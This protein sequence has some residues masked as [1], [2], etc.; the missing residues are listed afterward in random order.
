MADEHTRLRQQLIGES[1]I[2]NKEGQFDQQ[3]FQKYERLKNEE[4]KRR[5][6]KIELEKKKLNA[7]FEADLNEKYKDYEDMIKKREKRKAELDSEAMSMRERI[8]QNREAFKKKIDQFEGIDRNAIMRDLQKNTDAIESVVA[9][10]HREQY[11]KMKQKL[12]VRKKQVQRAKKAKE[13]VEKSNPVA[14]GV[15]G[16]F[17]K[18]LLKKQGTINLDNIQDDDSELFQ[19]LKAWKLRKQ[20]YIQQMA[21]NMTVDMEKDQIKSMVVKLLTIEEQLKELKRERNHTKHVGTSNIHGRG[22]SMVSAALV[23][24]QGRRESRWDDT[25]SNAGTAYDNMSRAGSNHMRKSRSSKRGTEEQF[26]RGGTSTSA[27]PMR[28]STRQSADGRSQR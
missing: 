12:E 23:S 15:F 2:V 25:R 14:Q 20:E 1:D 28:M 6:E 18:G 19:R 11:F 27:K 16:R 5:L 10:E 21:E 13:E 8:T 4:N 26:H 7:E 22:S 17:G 9:L 24:A 3:A